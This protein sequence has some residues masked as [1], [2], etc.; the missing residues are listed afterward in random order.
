[1]IL[2]IPIPGWCSMLP[3]RVVL[4]RR[5]IV[6]VSFNA[7]L[8]WTPNDDLLVYGG[9]SRGHKAGTFNLG[10]TARAGNIPGIPV[11]SEQLTSYEGGFKADF[12]DGAT[13]LNG[14][15]FYYDYEDSQ[16]FQ[17]DGITLTSQAFNSDADVLGMELELAAT[18]M[19]GLDLFATLT[20]LDATL[21]DVVFSGSVIYRP[22]AS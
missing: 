18:P 4:P 2:I 8:N 22:G 19:D 20:Y 21:K 9:V 3:R 11:K 17:F 5:M 15:V 13:R 10:F 6:L 16:A 14:A 1:M 7:R 12:M